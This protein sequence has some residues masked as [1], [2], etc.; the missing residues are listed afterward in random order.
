MEAFEQVDRL[1]RQGLE[2]GAYPSA[3]LAVGI[4][5]TTYL[6]RTYGNCTG[7]TL[8]DL[9]SVTKII[10]PTMIA[11]RFLE[12]GKLRLYDCVGDFF[13]GA[14]SDKKDI[15]ILQLLTHTSGMVAEFL[16]SD[17]TCD[18]GEAASVILNY[19]LAQAPGL[20]PIYSCMGYI[21]LGKI[22]EQIGGAPL[23]EMA[24]KYVFDP[25]GMTHTGY[26]P[27]GDIAPTERDP[28]TG[29]LIQGVVHDDNARFLGGISANAGAFSD[30][31]DMITFTQMLVSG[32]RKADGSRYLSPAM[33]RAALV[34]RTP[35]S[36]GEFRSLG[37]N[38]AHSPRNFL[39]DLMG[40]QAYGHT[41]FTGTSIAV[42]PDTGLWVVL[43]TNR[44]CPTRANTT[45]VRMRSLIHNAAAAEASRLLSDAN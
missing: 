13:P 30:L 2:Q 36:R 14:P 9:A 43:L 42:D 32:G 8:F 11:F 35:N 7:N 10:G 23:D 6:K 33:F 15:T 38:L 20:D 31:E 4:G 34:N 1:L 26:R 44:V 18:P 17:Y 28:K 25:L 40:P 21:L 22:L 3:A 27:T 37:F 5:R 19:P 41:G 39:G 24:R 12:D 16:L 45:L 29:Q